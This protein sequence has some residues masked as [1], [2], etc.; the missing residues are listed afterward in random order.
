MHA[1]DD[2]EL[3]SQKI[4]LLEDEL[5]VM[6]TR[7]Q[8]L[9]SVILSNISHDIR[10]PMNAIVG[11]A[12]LLTNDNMDSEERSDCIDHINNHSTELLK[13]VDNMIDASQL[14][15]GGIK[16]YDKECY[17]NDFLDEIYAQTLE[18]K[19]INQEKLS[20][21]VSKGEGDD[22]FILAD[23][24]RLKQ[25]LNNLIDN[26]I[27]F[28]K[29]GYVEFGYYT[30]SGNKITFFVRDT[31]SGLAALNKEELFVPFRSTINPKNNGA[32]KGAGL[33]LAISKD[34]VGLMGGE[35]WPDSAPG[36]GT[37]FYFTLP[38]KK[39]SFLACKLQQ[40]TT[41]TKRNIASL[42]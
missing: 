27:K 31:G 12:N 5:N 11:F 42:F 4:A 17:V 28:T 10:T 38:I 33:G 2:N 29:E 26:A 7:T 1:K 23:Y 14:Q 19:T 39:T 3:L 18:S 30:S 35:I 6:R 37:C 25:I 41:I 32:L 16:L 21:E 20:L 24:K 22:F 40:V 34:L 9:Q 13:I 36:K 8:K 15:C